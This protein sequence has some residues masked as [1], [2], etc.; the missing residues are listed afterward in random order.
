MKQARAKLL[1]DK[2]IIGEGVSMMS[3]SKK[4]VSLHD[5]LYQGSFTSNRRYRDKDEDAF[6]H[7]ITAWRV[8]QINY[9]EQKLLLLDLEHIDKEIAK[10]PVPEAPPVGVTEEAA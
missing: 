3:A 4:A 6:E 9:K 8:I 1:K 7:E 2:Q 5:V 10:V